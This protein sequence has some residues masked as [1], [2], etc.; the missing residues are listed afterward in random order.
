M[1]PPPIV[2]TPLVV[3]GAWALGHMG[4]SRCGARAQ[5][6]HGMRDL[7]GP[8]IEPVLRGVTSSSGRGAC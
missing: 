5:L 1:T 8:G 6:P 2:V 4:F 7:P 3:G